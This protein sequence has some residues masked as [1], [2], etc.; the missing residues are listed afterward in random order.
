MIRGTT[1]THIFTLPFEV[2]EIAALS[3]TYKQNGEVVFK[4]KMADCTLEGNNVTVELTQEETLQFAE[5]NNVEI[6]L[7]AKNAAG[8]VIAHSVKT[9]PVERILDDEVI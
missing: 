5:R 2:S 7:K 4:K 6:Q 9:I 8:K 1:P 3:V